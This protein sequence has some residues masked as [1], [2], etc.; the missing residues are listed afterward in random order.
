MIQKFKLHNLY[1]YINKA[2]GL[3]FKALGR[4]N[5]ENLLLL[6][7]ALEKALHDYNKW[8]D[9]YILKNSETQGNK[10]MLKPEA[11]PEFVKVGEEEIE[12]TYIFDFEETEQLEKNITS[13]DLE[14]FYIVF[15]GK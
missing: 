9:E 11:I 13:A 1:Q 3:K 6:N 15:G 4:K 8:R 10:T 12:F 7:V 14:P 5:A 2:G